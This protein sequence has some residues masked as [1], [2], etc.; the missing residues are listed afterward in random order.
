MFFRFLFG[1]RKYNSLDN[2]K[3]IDKENKNK[4][5]FH[6][7][8]APW[9]KIYKKSFLD[10]YTEWC[11]PKYLKFEDMP[12]HIQSCIRAESISYFD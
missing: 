1:N 12:F 4:F 2:Y 5:F 3:S 11:F 10:R 7:Y 8:F 6:L 9:F